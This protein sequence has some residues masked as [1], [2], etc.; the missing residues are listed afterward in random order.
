[1]AELNRDSIAR[2][3]FE[4]IDEFAGIIAE[5]LPHF[6]KIGFDPDDQSGKFFELWQKAGLTILQTTTIQ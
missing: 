3:A 1:M 4:N 6:I 2:Y 5:V